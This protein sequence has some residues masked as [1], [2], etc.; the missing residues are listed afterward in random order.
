M[1]IKKRIGEALNQAGWY[2]I[3]GFVLLKEYLTNKIYNAES[4]RTEL[5]WFG[6][7]D[8][9]G[10]VHVEP[11][12]SLNFYNVELKRIPGKI[13]RLGNR[14]KKLSINNNLVSSLPGSIKSLKNLEVLD[15]SMNRLT[16]LPYE[17]QLLKKLRVLDIRA[18]N[19][20]SL[21]S[22][23]FSL[24]LE[25]LFIDEEFSKEFIEQAMHETNIYY[26]YN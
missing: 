21:P 13:F 12:D 24:S 9:G 6:K 7:T 22:V 20:S 11:K 2:V 1:S 15:V 23:L 5:K 8:Y 25:E 26:G 18:N 10:S 14:V 4:V 3:G 17:L 16:S 19:F